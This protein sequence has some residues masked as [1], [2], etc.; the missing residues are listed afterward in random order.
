MLQYIPAL[1]VLLDLVS[2]SLVVGLEPDSSYPVLSQLL[3]I[4]LKTNK[5]NVSMYYKYFLVHTSHGLH[6]RGINLTIFILQLNYS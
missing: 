6:T 5:K 4:K 3:F 2:R 1:S